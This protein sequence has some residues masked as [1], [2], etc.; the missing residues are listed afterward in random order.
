MPAFRFDDSKAFDENWSAFIAVAQ[1]I[2]ADMAAILS[3]NKERVSAVVRQGQSNT[4]ARVAF[5]A[6]VVKA[7]DAFLAKPAEGGGRS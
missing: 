2:D 1:A 7:L 5:N 3:A 4:N 6:E